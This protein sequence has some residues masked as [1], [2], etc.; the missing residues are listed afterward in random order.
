MQDITSI[1]LHS[2]DK[3]AGVLKTGIVPNTTLFSCRARSQMAING[4]SL[5][6]GERNTRNM[7]PS[8]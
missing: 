8:K 6:A 5:A 2:E 7:R 4:N 3:V 1:L